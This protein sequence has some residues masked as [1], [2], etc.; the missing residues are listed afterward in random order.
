MPTTLTQIAQ[1]TESLS[2]LAARIKVL[3]EALPFETVLTSQEVAQAAGS[4][5]KFVLELG[6]TLPALQDYSQVSGKNRWFGSPATI[7]RLREVLSCPKASTPS[8]AKP[9]LKAASHPT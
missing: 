5:F 4:R 2:P 3:L 6:R 7:R 9:G 8:P 1:R